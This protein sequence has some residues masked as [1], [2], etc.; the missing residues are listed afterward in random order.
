MTINAITT[1]TINDKSNALV[2]AAFHRYGYTVD[3]FKDRSNGIPDVSESFG[4]SPYDFRTVTDSSQML[5]LDTLRKYAESTAVK[6]ALEHGI[7]VKFVDV[8]HD[9]DLE[10][11][12]TQLLH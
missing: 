2:M 6:V 5:G 10:S 3:V 12:M 9:V 11:E 1:T 4:N 7:D 8:F